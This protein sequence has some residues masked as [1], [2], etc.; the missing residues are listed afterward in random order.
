MTPKTISEKEISH[1]STTLKPIS[2]QMNSWAEKSI[3]LKWGVLSRGKF[4]CLE[5]T[6]SWKPE[7]QSKPCEKYIKCTACQGRLKMQGCNQVHFREIEYCA[8][9]DVCAGYQVVRIIC[10]HKHMKKNTAPTY[11]HKEVM[12][13]WINPKG[14]VRT[15]SLST[16]VFSNVYDAWQYYSPLEIRPKDFQNSPKYRINPYKVFPQLKVLPVL[17][18]NGFKTGFYNITPQILFTSLLKDSITETLLKSSQ[19]SLLSYYLISHEQHIRENWQAVKT[20]LKYRYKIEDF[21]IWE[22]YIALLRWFKKDLSSVSLIC[23]ENLHE[24]HDKLVAKKRELQR[25][26]YLLKMRAEIQQAQVL[27]TLEKKQFFGLRFSE[28]DI[29]ISVL[30]NVSEFIEEGDT[31]KHCVFTNE[32]Y[33]KKD[34][35]LLSA[36]IDNKPVETIEVSLSNMEVV[37][38][39]G[40]KNN[41]SKHHKVILNLMNRNLYQ[42]YSRLK[43]EK[44][45]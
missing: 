38:C 16:N 31:L 23:P 12:Q 11:F 40:I 1:L 13:H 21:R 18:R 33:K 26:K 3:F 20:C 7:S 43:K 19:T 44:R 41:K 28:G 32:Y 42:I 34:S 39:R 30:E 6:H 27:Y 8:V 17:K 14:E 5:C 37:Q 10:S 2:A 9:L 22:D 45:C 35:L 29:T 25:K 24:V 36:R 15:M 4:H